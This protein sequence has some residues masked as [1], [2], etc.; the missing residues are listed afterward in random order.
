MDGAK[1]ELIVPSAHPAHQNR[2]AIQEV[3][4]ILVLDARSTVRSAAAR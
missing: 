3:Q 2:Q 1:S 4:R